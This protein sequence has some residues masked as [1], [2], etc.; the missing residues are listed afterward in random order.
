M[1]LTVG[2]GRFCFQI[3][4]HLLKFGLLFRL[5]INK[6]KAKGLALYPANLGQIDTK[7]PTEPR[8]V[9]TALKG[10]PDDDRLVRFD[11]AAPIR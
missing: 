9:H 1:A 2:L 10:C 11:P 4:N 5:H 6:L 8:N 3:N 7:R